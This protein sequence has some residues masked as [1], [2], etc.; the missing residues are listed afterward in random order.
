MGYWCACLGINQ[1]VTASAKLGI[2]HPGNAYTKPAR[3]E[4]LSQIFVVYL[5]R[6]HHP[7]YVFRIWM[8][9]RGWAW[10]SLSTEPTSMIAHRVC[11]D[12][13][14][15]MCTS[16][17]RIYELGG[18]TY[19]IPVARYGLLKGRMSIDDLRMGRVIYGGSIS[20]TYAGDRPGMS[21]DWGRHE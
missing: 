19:P 1:P 7:G 8:L 14:H 15:I 12:V 18:S 10:R 11:Y 20:R 16:I 6:V 13:H 9:R 3:V 5:R 21:A 17:Y 4:P 2:N